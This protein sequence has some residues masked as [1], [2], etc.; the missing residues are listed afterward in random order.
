MTHQTRRSRHLI[1]ALPLL[2]I[3]GGIVIGLVAS[4]V[5]GPSQSP[6]SAAVSQPSPTPSAIAAAASTPAAGSQRPPATSSPSLVAKA[7][8]KPTATVQPAS[9]APATVASCRAKDLAGR[10]LAWD[11]AAGSRIA[12]LELENTAAI[13]C[14]VAEPSALRLIAGG[15]TIL[16]DSSTITG[17]VAPAPDGPAVTVAAG[18]SIQT[19]VRV[20]NYCGPTPE[21]PIGISLSLPGSG[22][23]VVAKSAPGVSSADAVPPCNGPVGPEIE[24]NGWR[25]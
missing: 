18:K 9:S 17:D 19:D 4:V 11:G 25:Q 8:S 1:A 22:G 2:G 21:S 10:I 6:V 16:I 7:T 14:T 20:A 13:T 12:E 24:M 5:L 15:G 3:T 23:T